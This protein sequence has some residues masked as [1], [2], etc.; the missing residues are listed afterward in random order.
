MFTQKVPVLRSAGLVALLA[1]AFAAAVWASQG[2]SSATPSP[3][4]P[5]ADC[6]SLALPSVD[7]EVNTVLDKEHGVMQLSFYDKSADTERHVTIDYKSAACL[8]QPD[9]KRMVDHV[10]AA[11]AGAQ[12]QACASM[13]AALNAGTTRVR[14]RQVDPAAGRRYLA[15][16]C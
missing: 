5:A 9:L 15:E 2:E 1:A 14:G 6:A 3:L 12:A 11:G 16:S 7:G 13:R 8:R 4:G 10:L